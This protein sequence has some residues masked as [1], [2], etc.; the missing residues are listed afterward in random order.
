MPKHPGP[1]HGPCH[2]PSAVISVAF[3]GAETGNTHGVTE[4]PPQQNVSNWA[5][6]MAQ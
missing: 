5:G 3:E 2:A 1:Q 6:G 4:Y